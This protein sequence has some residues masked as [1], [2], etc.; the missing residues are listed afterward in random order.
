MTRIVDSVGQFHAKNV[1]PQ[2]LYRTFFISHTH[3]DRRLPA[4]VSLPLYADEGADRVT[5]GGIFCAGH[6]LLQF[7]AGHVF[8]L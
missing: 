6:G 2:C 4:V 3:R 5:G 1:S 7:G 8:S